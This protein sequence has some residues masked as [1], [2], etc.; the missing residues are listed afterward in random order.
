MSE[1]DELPRIFQDHELEKVR[2]EALIY[3]CACPAQVAQSIAQLRGL[4]AYQQACEASRHD[5]LGVHARIAEAV[6]V[7]HAT[8]EDC[9]EDILRVEGWDRTTLDMPPGLRALQKD[10]ILK[11]EV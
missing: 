6:R 9:L 10:H 4:F 11:D 1:K 2:E 8:L 7:A 5:E 3:M